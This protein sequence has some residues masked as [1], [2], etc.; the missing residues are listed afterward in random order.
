MKEQSLKTLNDLLL[1]STEK[2][3]EGIALAR[4]NDYLTYNQLNT[5]AQSVAVFLQN[6]GI[7]PGDHVAILSENSPLWGVVF[8]GI[9]KAGG[10]VVSLDI[11]NSEEELLYVLN[12]SETKVCFASETQI[13]KLH[14][15]KDRFATIKHIYQTSIIENLPP[16]NHKPVEID[17]SSTAILIYTSGTMGN[18]KGVMLS[19]SNIIS[20]IMGGFTYIPYNPATSFVSLIPLSHMFGINAGFLGPLYKGATV[21][22]SKS[23]KG[24]EILKALNQSK[25]EILVLVPL[26]LK[27]FYQSITSKI[28]R[29]S[30][31]K[32]LSFY[33]L[34][35][36]ATSSEK[37]GITIGKWLFRKIHKSLGGHLKYFISGGAP[38]EPDIEKFFNTVGIPILNGYGLTETSPLVSVNSLHNR[39]I[40]SA[41]RVIPDIELRISS[42]GE[43]QIHGPTVMKGYFKDTEA[44][45]QVIENGW[46]KTGDIGEVDKDG[47]LFIKDRIKNVIVLP[48]GLKIFPNEIE[49]EIG[50]SP[51]FIETCVIKRA[52]QRGEEPMLVIYPDQYLLKG[53]SLDDKRSKIRQELENYQKNLPAYKKVLDFEIWNEELPKTSTKKVKRKTLEIQLNSKTKKDKAVGSDNFL[54]N[55]QEAHIA[56][57]IGKFLN[58][59]NIEID[60]KTNLRNDLGLDSIMKI[61]LISDI[62]KDLNISI[63]EEIIYTIE[64]FTDLIQTINNYSEKS[65]TEETQVKQEE[66]TK[67]PGIITKVISSILIFGFLKLLFKIEIV[68]GDRIPQTGT[69][70]I[71]ANHASMLDF[72]VLS[73]IL[74]RK[75][76]KVISVPAAYDYFYKKSLGAWFFRAGFNMF[77]MKRHGNYYDGLKICAQKIK[78]GKPLIVFP[79]GTRSVS[80]ELQKFKPG[81]GL[82]AFD[83]NVPL[84]PMYIK[85]AYKALPKGSVIPKPGKIQ[86]IVGEPI[87]ALKF[88][89]SITNEPNYLIYKKITE[90][91]RNTIEL[92][93]A[94]Y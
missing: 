3:P 38:L 19:H 84:I 9:I 69:F 43:I 83:L 25:T 27:K 77:P 73:A 5:S 59:S 24:E 6:Q 94:E 93:I 12:H 79:E 45:Q 32:K 41:G 89:N 46:F 18:Q 14:T 65:E 13:H 16:S 20:N 52:T 90:E 66:I 39:K 15:I 80:G 4:D 61:E 51:M 48:S 23:L 92:L 75:V 8:F 2:Y 60:H 88:K 62:E 10:I 28:N 85:G 54:L 82:L 42:E 91:V 63:P 29:Y 36:L 7:K 1:Q 37:L 68:N 33:T 22:Y 86:V 26:I 70:I 40:G 71:V 72:P 56:S 81:I 11:L 74:P 50:R 30:L 35:L 76:R 64:S 49:L 31:I 44:T 47:Y 57:I 53:L 67:E 55:N 87:H 17:G 21:T 78:E 34:F 58:E